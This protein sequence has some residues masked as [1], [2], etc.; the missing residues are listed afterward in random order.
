MITIADKSRC[1]GCAACA[2]R[3]PQ[4]CIT[5]QE[6]N[7]GFLYPHVNVEAC[8]NCNMC[9]SVCPVLHKDAPVA[10]LQ[11]FAVKNPVDAIRVQS[12]SGG[13]F[14]A[15]AET[16]LSDGGVVIGASFDDNWE[17]EHRCAENLEQ[18]TALRRSKYVQ[19]RVGR[20]YECAE[21]Y[22]K[23]GRKVLFTGTPCQIAGLRHFLHREYEN[24]ICADVMCHGVPSPLVW[25]DYLGFIAQGNK[26]Q[27]SG[28]SFRN[29]ATGWKKYS[30][31]VFSSV[32][33]TI[34]F[35]ERQ[36][37]NAYM[38]GFIKNLYLRPICYNCPFRCGSCGSDVTLGDFWGVRR[39]M[40]DFDDDCGVSLVLLNSEKGLRF[41]SSLRMDNRPVTYKQSLANNKA[42][43]MPAVRPQQYY[44]FWELYAKDGITAIDAVLYTMRPGILERAIS[45]TKRIVK[46]ILRR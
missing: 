25:R 28:I 26:N 27:I 41:Y 32:D 5:M 30:L 4:Q 19:S 31:T 18:L 34:I 44:K 40:R 38:R 2:Q 36:D 37:K 46:K 39:A 22:L 20:T 14:N 29:K 8:V 12:S 17:V 9:E 45:L 11:I 10:P 21:K 23:G 13:V 43:Q 33:S 15:L 42:W 24:L 1:C 16:I 35:S 6:D 7:Q 3:C